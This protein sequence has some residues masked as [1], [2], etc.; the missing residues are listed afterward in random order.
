MD[1]EEEGWGTAK[2]NDKNESWVL[3]LTNI[4]H[5]IRF[6]ASSTNCHGVYF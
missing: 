4:Y 5:I 1:G 6:I 2:H 3:N